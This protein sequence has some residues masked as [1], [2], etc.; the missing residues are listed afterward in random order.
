MNG[1]KPIIYKTAMCLSFI[2]LGN[3]RMAILYLA[4]LL[5]IIKTDFYGN[6]MITKNQKKRRPD[7]DEDLWRR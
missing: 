3:C 6:A 4:E 1:I 5:I 2:R 7:M